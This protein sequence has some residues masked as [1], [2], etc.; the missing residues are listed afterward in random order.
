MTKI[1]KVLDKGGIDKDDKG[2]DV[3]VASHVLE[4]HA[5][6]AQE[7]VAKGRGRFEI[8]DDEDDSPVD[9]DIQGN[10]NAPKNAKGKRGQ[11]AAEAQE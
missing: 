6:D 10:F 5:V 9:H 3:K 7:I 2:K 8:L 4:R 1:V 11:D